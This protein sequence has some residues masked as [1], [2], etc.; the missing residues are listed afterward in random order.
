MSNTPKDAPK[1]SAKLDENRDDGKTKKNVRKA[2][3][4]DLDNTQL[5]QKI[6]DKTSSKTDPKQ[7]EDLY[8]TSDGTTKKDLLNKLQK[9]Q[10]IKVK[11]NEL[12]KIF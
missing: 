2:E 10:N 8:K 6:L 3:K 7:V 5:K 9:T 4:S 12:E 11:D 1:D